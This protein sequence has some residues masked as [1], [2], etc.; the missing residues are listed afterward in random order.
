[1][2]KLLKSL[3]VG[4]FAIC[5]SCN[6]LHASSSAKKQNDAFQIKTKSTQ[7]QNAVKPENLP[8]KDLTDAGRAGD[9]ASE[10][11]AKN[12]VTAVKDSG[13]SLANAATITG[14]TLAVLGAAAAGV[15]YRTQIRGFL[16]SA[17]DSL[18]SSSSS[19]VSK[20]AGLFSKKSV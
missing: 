14:A 8:T 7:V 16:T 5:L 9:N 17:Y 19:L 4:S 13:V 15:K 18:K 10:D 11:L 3:L 2:S 6:C 20:V 12:A 1:M